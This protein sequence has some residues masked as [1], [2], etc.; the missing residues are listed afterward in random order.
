MRS[1]DELKAIVRGF[2]P[3]IGVYPPKF[4]TAED[5]RAVYE[6]WT[7]AFVDAKAYMTNG[8]DSEQALWTMAELARQGHNMDIEGMGALAQE[9]IEK[10]IS[11]Y[12]ESRM[13]HFSAVNYYLSIRVSGE[14]VA[15]L[16]RSLNV[17]KKKIAPKVNKKVEE[18]LVFYYY[19]DRRPELAMKQIDTYLSYFPDSKKRG[20]F[21]QMRADLAKGAYG[22]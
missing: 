12:P 8:G 3:V 7:D 5:K 17:L 19:Y 2:D 11:K 6:E 21:T 1:L 22:S 4:E 9:Q 16:G 10:C 13:C 18:S 15:A 20:E 14:S